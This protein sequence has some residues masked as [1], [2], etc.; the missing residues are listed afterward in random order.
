VDIFSASPDNYFDLILMDV[1][2]PVMDG[3]TATRAIRALPRPDAGKVPIFAMTANAFKDDIQM[4]VESGM[5]GHIAKPVEF[6]TAMEV[7][8]QVFQREK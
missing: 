7:I 2:M 8:G 4:V 6:D 1:Q 3:C 5:N